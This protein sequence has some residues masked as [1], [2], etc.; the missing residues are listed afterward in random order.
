MK[1]FLSIL[2]LLSLVFFAGSCNNT[3]NTKKSVKT[4]SNATS[5]I[6]YVKESNGNSLVKIKLSDNIDACYTFN[7]TI[8]KVFTVKRDFKYKTKNNGE[9]SILLSDKDY[10]EITDLVN[11]T[12]DFLDSDDNPTDNEYYFDIT[13][14]RGE[15]YTNLTY[16]DYFRAGYDQILTKLIKLSPI[17]IVDTYNGK[18]T[19]DYEDNFYV[20]DKDKNKNIDYNYDKKTK[21]LS[22]T[23]TGKMEDYEYAPP[24]QDISYTPENVVVNNG[25]TRICSDAF[26]AGVDGNS[27]EPRY[28]FYLTKNIKIPESVTE[29][30]DCA[31]YY[32]HNLQSIKLPKKLNKIGERAFEECKSIKT[33]T[34][35]DE[36][37]KIGEYFCH[38]CEKLETVNF[39]KGITKIGFGA[40]EETNLKR[41]VL[42]A[43]LK[44]ICYSAFSWNKNLNEVIIPNG[45]KTIEE[46]AFFE[47]N[48][49]KS[50][51]IPSSVKKIEQHAFGYVYND[52]ASEVKLD[53][54]TIK[55]K[56]GSVAEKYAKS[57]SFTFIEV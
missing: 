36:V 12:K 54:F 26:S 38:G 55:G 2:L 53:G 51:N 43:S 40:F 49:L 47:C 50:V 22:F 28:Y 17:K 57:N 29:I 18:I 13:T 52:D 45:V 24:W 6:T 46:R 41:V 11:N 37:T 27:G 34:I 33:L 16:G 44:T 5:K 31:F 14:I 9:K 20:E 56:K 25:I 19:V 42:P 23:G 48:N 15:K 4:K 39:G 3:N 21:T 7:V 32:C 1:K 8:D 35:P 30:G 10:K